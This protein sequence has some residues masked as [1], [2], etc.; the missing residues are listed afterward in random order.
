MKLPRLQVNGVEHNPPDPY[1]N[2][3]SYLRFD[4]GLTGTYQRIQRAIE[5]AAEAMA[6]GKP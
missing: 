1:R 2:L 6:G 4:V 5:E 3:L